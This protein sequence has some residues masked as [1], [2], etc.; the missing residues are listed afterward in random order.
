MKSITLTTFFIIII[1]I[2]GAALSFTL[3]TS[4]PLGWQLIAVH[5]SLA[6]SIML[7]V[8]YIG[9]AFLFVFGLKKFKVTLKVAYGYICFGLFILA[10]AQLQLPVFQFLNL[11]SSEWVISGGIQIPYIIAAVLLFEGVRRFSNLVKV[12]NILS[13]WLGTAFITISCILIIYIA[14]DIF[15]PYRIRPGAQITTGFAFIAVLIFPILCAITSLLTLS[16]KQKAGASYSN[17]LAWFFIALVAS[18]FTE[19]QIPFFS[20][21]GFDSGWVVKGWLSLPFV[22]SGL[23]FLKAGHAFNKISI[24]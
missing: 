12:N 15:Y 1:G 22:I 23:L 5:F 17:A 4:V 16:I 13:S 9:T 18:A 11:F 2:I 6:F 7:A 19:G 3:R 20:A 8:Y 21:V 24:Y 14:R 10:I